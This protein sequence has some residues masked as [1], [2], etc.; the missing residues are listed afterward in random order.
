MKDFI[1]MEQKEFEEAISNFTIKIVDENNGTVAYEI[2]RK[3]KTA[4]IDVRTYDINSAPLNVSLKNPKQPVKPFVE[5]KVGPRKGRK[6]RGCFTPDGTFDSIVEAAQFYNIDKGLMC[7][8]VTAKV[9]KGVLG[10]GFI[11]HD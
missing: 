10:W 5:P 4:T 9:K 3:P 6:A 8:R 1:T 11:K 2:R 7:C